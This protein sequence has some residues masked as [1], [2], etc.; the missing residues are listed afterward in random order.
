MKKSLQTIPFFVFLLPVFFVLH[1]YRENLGYIH[2][3]DAILLAAFYLTCAAIVFGLTYLFY[4]HVARAALAATFLLDLFFLFRRD[5]GFSES[6]LSIPVP[7]TPFSSRSS[8]S[9]SS[10]G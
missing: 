6:T 3:G 8:L 4:R 9:P 5:P 2:P 7:L 1:G 10:P